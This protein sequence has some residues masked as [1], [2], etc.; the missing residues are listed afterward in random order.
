MASPV[1]GLIC[2]AAL[3]LPLSPLSAAQRKLCEM[4][5]LD[6]PRDHDKD[7]AKVPLAAIS[8]HA[9]V[10]HCIGDRYFSRRMHAPA[11]ILFVIDH[12]GSMQEPDK[13]NDLQDARFA[14]V[15]QLL[16]QIYEIHPQTEVGV[17]SFANRLSFDW[18]DRELFT[19][20]NGI[21]PIDHDSYLALHALNDSACGIDCIQQ[22][23]ETD[24]SRPADAD[25]H[26]SPRLVWGTRRPMTRTPRNDAWPANSIRHGADITLALQAAL[27]AFAATAIPRERRFIVFLSSGPAD[28][29]DK[30]RED[31]KRLYYDDD[32]TL[33]I[34]TTFTIQFGDSL[35]STLVRMTRLI[36]DNGYSAANGMSE[37]WSIQNPRYELLELLDSIVMNKMY[38]AA[39]AFA[40]A[41][42]QDIGAGNA[43]GA[44]F[45][46]PGPFPLS[47]FTDSLHFR[48]TFP[49]VNAADPEAEPFGTTETFDI[50]V[51]RN[52]HASL[53]PWIDTVCYTRILELHDGEGEIREISPGMNNVRILCKT[54]AHGETFAATR[55]ARGTAT[56]S[57]AR[58]GDSYSMSCSTGADRDLYQSFDLEIN[59]RAIPDDSTIQHAAADTLHIVWRG[60]NHSLDTIALTVPIVPGSASR[61]NVRRPAPLARAPRLA[62]RG[63]RLHIETRG[64]RLD[65]IQLVNARGKSAATARANAPAR[66]LSLPTG[67]LAPGVYIAVVT[68]HGQPE[69]RRLIPLLID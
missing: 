58:T 35:D 63:G 51:N 66:A 5:F 25:P 46:F 23:L 52:R 24:S 21:R 4:I 49:V 61:P 65:G 48:Y 28:S 57:S 62:M 9:R 40:T 22:L 47:G 16:T 38:T 26:Y 31:L 60:E 55:L 50:F 69:E 64:T 30:E 41:H 43:T 33:N 14:V 36:R 59:T 27:E 32:F 3:L 44:Y 11:A 37:M 12:S 13:G 29:V 42:I 67:S 1:R 54:L 45:E 2:L 39:T 56:V 53:S 34:P 18:R 68:L 20:M 6:C 10:K 17:V 7:T 19:R 8:L 15:R